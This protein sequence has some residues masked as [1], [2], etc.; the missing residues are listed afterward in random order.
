MD[1][2]LLTLG[3]D[4][5]AK[6]VHFDP[7]GNVEGLQYTQDVQEVVDWCHEAEDVGKDLHHV[8]RYPPGELILFGKL[9]GVN[10]PAWYLKPEYADLMDKLINDSGHRR[11][12]VWQGRV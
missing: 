3:D 7:D 10:D 4:G 12:R 8:G 5:L 9:N 2:K 6:Y 1:R 11:L